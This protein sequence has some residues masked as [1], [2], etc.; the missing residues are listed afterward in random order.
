MNYEAQGILNVPLIKNGAA[1]RIG[2]ERGHES[3]YIDQVDQTTLKK[4]AKDINTTTTPS[5]SSR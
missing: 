3:G 5:S 2:V 1:L 4:I